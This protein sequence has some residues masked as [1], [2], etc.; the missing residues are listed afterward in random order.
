MQRFNGKRLMVLAGAAALSLTMAM[1]ALADTATTTVD[2][3]PAVIASISG[4][5]VL[6][7]G[8]PAG[9]D[10]VYQHTGTQTV[11]GGFTIAVDDATG[12]DAGWSVSVAASDF[13][14][15]GGR[16][17]DASTNFEQ[18]SPSVVTGVAGDPASGVDATADPQ[19]LDL[20]AGYVV[21]DADAGDGSG[22]YTATMP[23]A[24]TIPAQT[25]VGTY[26]STVTVTVGA[27]LV[28]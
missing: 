13:A 26:V 8:G 18:S 16:I 27:A 12:T 28:V 5:P 22:S 1:P 23:V 3:A 19:L 9:T 10:P 20:E 17:I 7:V 6:K 15:G 2:G 24:L 4:S 25:L 21:L 14:A 11:T